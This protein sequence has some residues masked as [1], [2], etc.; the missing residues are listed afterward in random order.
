MTLRQKLMLAIAGF[1]GSALFTWPIAPMIL[2]GF[3]EVN[4]DIPTIPEPGKGG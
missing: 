1:I 4:G 2:W 3:A